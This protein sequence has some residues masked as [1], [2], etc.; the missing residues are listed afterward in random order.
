MV[1]RVADLPLALILAARGDEPDELLTRIA[2]HASTT[3]A[4]AEAAVD[5]AAVATLAGEERAAAVQRPPAAS[6]STSTRC[7]P[8]DG[9]AAPGDRLDRTA[10]GRGCRPRAPR[11]P[12]RS[13]VAGAGGTIAARLAGLDVR[14]AVEAAEA[15]AAADILRGDDFAH[16][17]VQQA[18]YAAIGRGAAR[19]LHAA[20]ARLVPGRSGSPRR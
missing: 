4:H 11:S 2:L 17:L 16:P 1:N 10:A 6:R 20:A 14:G 12:A 5:A 19:E 7:S 15:L 18:V 8:S 9:D 13:A 3:R